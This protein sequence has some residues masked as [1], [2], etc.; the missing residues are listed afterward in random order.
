LQLEIGPNIILLIRDELFFACAFRE[1]NIIA[2]AIF[3][4]L[5]RG[6]HTV[7]SSDS[8]GF[9]NLFT[10]S[11]KYLIVHKLLQIIREHSITFHIDLDISVGF[12]D[13]N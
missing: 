7:E 3:A 8:R 5:H 10:I 1:S 2:Y 11:H 13:L 9:C 12:M 4:W 6:I